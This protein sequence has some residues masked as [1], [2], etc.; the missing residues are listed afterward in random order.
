[1][2]H[3]SDGCSAVPAALLPTA[4]A[5]AGWRVAQGKAFHRPKRLFDSSLFTF[6]AL[7]P[8]VWSVNVAN[9]AP[10]VASLTE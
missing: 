1:M 7:A 2:P 5:F 9:P 4:D 8:M 3:G 6:F 10:A